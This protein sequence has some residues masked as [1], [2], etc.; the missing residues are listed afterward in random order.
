MACCVHVVSPAKC[1]L[2]QGPLTRTSSQ[3]M[4]N[5]TRMCQSCCSATALCNTSSSSFCFT[6]PSFR[7]RV[8]TTSYAA[9][10]C[11][12]LRD[13]VLGRLLSY[14]LRFV[15]YCMCHVVVRHQV[16]RQMLARS[17]VLIQ[18]E[19]RPQG[20]ACSRH[21]C[22]SPG[23]LVGAL[24]SRQPVQQMQPRNSTAVY[25]SCVSALAACSMSCAPATLSSVRR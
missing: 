22:W 11:H 3:C 6:P 23:Y 1:S 9:M 10:F 15:V 7:T 20:Y 16:Q 12:S 25:M 18:L 2:P 21:H 17:G 13:M 14:L 5:T 4:R 19:P 8:R 24:Q